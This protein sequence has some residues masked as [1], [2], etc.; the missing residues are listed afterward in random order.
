MTEVNKAFH[1]IDNRYRMDET[2]CVQE[3]L[4]DAKLPQPLF[5]AVQEKARG[6]VSKVRQKRLSQSGIDAFM[7]QY[8]LSSEEGIALMCLA[9][10][11]LRIPDKDTVDSLI[12]DKLAQGNW[13]AHAGK[14]H[15]LF[16]N[17]AT[18][19]LMLT[20]KIIDIPP[21]HQRE[22]QENTLTMALK[23]LANFG[24]EPIVRKAINQAMK[25]LG[26]QFVM[27]R[28]INGA[29]KRSRRKEEKGYRYSF[30]MLGEAAFT[31][32]DAE[33]YFIAYQKAIA[34]VGEASQGRGPVK[35][36]G[37]SVKLSALHPRYCIAKRERLH[38]ELLPKL[39]E[40]VKQA[41]AANMGLTIDAE[42]AH[43]LMISLELIEA[44]MDSGVIG[45]WQ[46]FGI[47]VQ[48]YQ[49]RAPSVLDWLIAK[50][51]KTQ[52]RLMIRLVKGAYW[53]TEIKLAQVQGLEGYP[54]FTRKIATDVNY[55]VCAKRMLQAPDAIYPQFA[56]HNALSLSIVYEL[57]KEY[58]VHDYE[59]QCLHGMGDALYDEI[60][61]DA[62]DPKPCRVY[63]PVGTHEEL[64][65]YLVRRLLENGAN[66]SFVNR[67]VDEKL[68]IE[69]MIVNPVDKLAELT[70][71]PHPGIPLPIDLYQPARANS[72]GLDLNRESS[73]LPVLERIE[74]H[75]NTLYSAAP[76]TMALGIARTINDRF[77]PIDRQH[78]LGKV[79]QAHQEDVQETL[80]L[81]T[82]AFPQW[83]LTQATKRAHYLEKMAALL[84][85]HAIEFYSLL[86]FEGGKTLDDAVSEVREAIDFCYYYALQAKLH[87][88]EPQTLTGPT[89]ELNQLSL[90]GRGVIACI[91]PWN[92]PL[93]I[94]LGQ[95][96]ASLAA[97]NCVV[98]KPASQT[99][100]I[101][102][103]AVELL[104]EAGFPKEVVQ[105]LPG[106]GQVVGNALVV[107]PRIAGVVFTGS[108]DTAHD[109]NQKLA[110]RKG[111]IVPF[112]A[113]TG[114]Q[115]A[116][117]V[118]SSA[119]CEQ[120][121]QDVIASA[122]RSAGQR[123]SALRV[124]FVQEE[125][126]DKVLTMIQG[127]MAELT[128]GNPQLLSTDVG[129]VID[130]SAQKQL[131]AHALKMKDKA[132]LLMEVTLSEGCEK[133]TFLAPRLFEIPSLD[134]LTEEV[135]G[136]ILHVVRYQRNQLDDVIAQINRT[137]YGLTMGIHSRINENIDYIRERVR[138]GNLYVN[139]NMIG[140]VVGVQPFGGEGLS[141]TGPKAGGPHYLPRLATERTVSI[142]TTASGGNAS[143]MSLTES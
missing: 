43:S 82:K 46:G 112:I 78:H 51:R 75:K 53:D 70:V 102:A 49:K 140:A 90:H 63:A 31:Q 22:A 35:G 142:N 16:V 1:A 26:R 143:L 110:A 77:S 130:E 129:P 121:T 113:E 120:V 138:V 24:G 139:R 28:T 61:M 100:L 41:K 15:S 56:T 10:A 7:F 8:D 67:I 96:T 45:E 83:Q 39:I 101:G 34:A 117:I 93:A 81:A 65:A 95:V 68:P 131:M 104:H 123:C 47:A 60:V 116:M 37:I 6:L 30:D 137:G 11:L 25:I 62:H 33:K 19:A 80:K 5:H 105:L 13:Q 98:A 119:L 29:I 55:I 59:F 71:K 108:T 12:R 107:D 141:G 40:L 86:M 103:K 134:M 74:H 79:T 32:A 20:G 38:Q 66:S 135:F 132:K 3:L 50:A 23:R 54:V 21:K 69:E 2:A 91:S 92:F 73:F 106:S 118:D 136:P 72:K 122:F 109:I 124:L 126:A 89:G 14:S 125:V 133:G 114:G 48:A 18:W 44:V 9:E 57:A 88:Q 115:N 17:A 27:G 36:P 42:E 85:K 99:A 64:L 84:E 97:G 4:K 87:F 111:P 76:T 58:G 52:Q 128:V 127:A 94:F